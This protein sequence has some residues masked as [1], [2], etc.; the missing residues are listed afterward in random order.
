MIHREGRTPPSIPV[1]RSIRQTMNGNQL[2]QCSTFYTSDHGV[3]GFAQT[4]TKSKRR[5]T[6]KINPLVRSFARSFKCSEWEDSLGVQRQIA[7]GRKVIKYEA[8]WRITVVKPGVTSV[9]F[10]EA[11]DASGISFEVRMAHMR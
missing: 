9:T 7:V 11:I 6:I 10:G 3:N 8:R 2:L 5:K 4:C 1:I